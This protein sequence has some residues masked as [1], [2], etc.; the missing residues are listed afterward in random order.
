MAKD[1]YKYNTEDNF[2]LELRANNLAHYPTGRTGYERYY[3]DIQ[4]FW[5]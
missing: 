1:Y 4:G 3:T 2:E 5:R